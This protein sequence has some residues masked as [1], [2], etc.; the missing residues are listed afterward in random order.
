MTRKCYISGCRSN[1]VPTKK[2]NNVEK[3]YIKV[4]RLLRNADEQHLW[5]KDIPFK[6]GK[7]SQNYVISIK[8]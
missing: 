1:Y 2:E 7:F 6:N 3:Q 4:F 5:I 8:H